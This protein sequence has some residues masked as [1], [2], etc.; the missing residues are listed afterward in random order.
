MKNEEVQKILGQTKDIYDEVAEKY[1]SVRNEP[2]PEM[3]FLFGKFLRKEDNIL[4]MGCGNGRFYKSF[5]ENG[6]VYTGIDNSKNL[7]EIAKKTYPEGNFILASALNLPFIENSFDNVYSIA[8]LHHMPTEELRRKFIEE[9]KRVLKVGGHLILTVWDMTK[10]REEQEKNKKPFNI[11][12]LFTQ[13]LDSNDIFIPW[14]GAQDCYF[15]VFDM[16]KL[17]ILVEDCGLRIIERGEISIGK[18]PYNNLYV[19][20]KKIS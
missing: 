19:V 4:D 16:E 10:K 6:V 8:V 20:A 7:I 2:W 13:R 18:K 12:N 15:H 11:F 1:A 3:D 9:A 14:Y 5:L 17:R